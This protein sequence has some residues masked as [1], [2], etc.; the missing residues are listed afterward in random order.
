MDDVAL[1]F[2]DDAIDAVAELALKTGTG[3][4]ALRSILEG[5]LMDIMYD[6]PSQ[7]GQKRCIIDADVILKQTTAVLEVLSGPTADE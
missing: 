5:A 7:A 1:E 6:A 2:T 3:A 4:R